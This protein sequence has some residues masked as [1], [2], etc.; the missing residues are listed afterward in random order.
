MFPPNAL[1]LDNV[2]EAFLWLQLNRFL[3]QVY[4]N[5][6]LLS[7]RPSWQLFAVHVRFW[8]RKLVKFIYGRLKCW[9]II[10]PLRLNVFFCL[11]SEIF[12]V[13]SL[14]NLCR[15][16]RLLHGHYEG[17]DLFALKF[18]NK[19]WTFGFLQLAILN[20]SFSLKFFAKEHDPP[21][22]FLIHQ[23]FHFFAIHNCPEHLY[24]L[25][26]SLRSLSFFDSLLLFFLSYRILLFPLRS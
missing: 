6:L 20:L 10:E 19:G 21:K 22:H 25:F 18:L 14:E 13:L 4:N 11:R 15:R 26:Q 23:K 9:L 1:N 8:W 3:R 2:I 16:G 5:F 24:I 7:P 17:V 12:M